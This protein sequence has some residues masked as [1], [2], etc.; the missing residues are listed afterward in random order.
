VRFP[1]VLTFALML[2]PACAT[3]RAGA[4]FRVIP[5]KPDYVL[6]SPD[7]KDIPFPEVLGRYTG[8]GTGWVELRP[9]IE[10]RIEN[11]YFREGT[12][13]RGLAN[14]LGT[15]I[16]RYQVLA[17]GAL[18]Q[19]AV[20]SRLEQRPADQPPVEQLL[21]ESQNRY[22][23]HRLFYQVLLNKKT[24]V[25][26]AVLLSAES[27]DELDRVTDQLMSD[28]ESVCGGV[29][30]YCTAFPE[31]CTA[32]LEIEIV[33]NGHQRT[34]LWGSSLAEVTENHR[35]IEL[36]RLHVGALAP[37]EI[38]PRDREAL[39]LPLLPGDRVK[40]R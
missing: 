7:S 2:S 8:V 21:S 15:E 27:L 20:Q 17:T 29:S 4:S 31:A 34:V 30:T 13:K 5:A 33:V 6:R 10:L 16:A 38:D 39:R 9:E 1:L 28:P 36:F 23:H 11:A 22:R 25:R 26:S 19:I 37:V 14:F 3:R 40:W 12:P 24:D 35:R 32:S 18:K